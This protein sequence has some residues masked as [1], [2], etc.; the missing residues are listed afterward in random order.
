MLL[1]FNINL[2]CI[3]CMGSSK[4]FLEMTSS[5]FG[6]TRATSIRQLIGNIITTVRRVRKSQWYRTSLATEH[7][8]AAIIWFSMQCNRNCQLLLLA[9]SS[10]VVR[11]RKT[12]MCVVET[13]FLGETKVRACFSY[14]LGDAHYKLT[15][16]KMLCT[17]TSQLHTKLALSISLEVDGKI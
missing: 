5:A 4:R 12:V 3:G 11:T 15:I 7:I 10:Y 2:K 13:I 14:I 16:L 6:Y 1:C 9:L 17:L 8:R